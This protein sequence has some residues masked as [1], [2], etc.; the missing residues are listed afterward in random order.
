MADLLK[1]TVFEALNLPRREIFVAATTRSMNEL[2][3]DWKAHPPAELRWRPAESIDFRSLEFDM[4]A[5]EAV[6]FIKKYAL[7]VVPDGWKIVTSERIF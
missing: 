2:I 1:V 7:T 5:E 6:A 3:A 4:N